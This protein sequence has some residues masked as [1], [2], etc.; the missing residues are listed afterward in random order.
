MSLPAE[1]S[2]VPPAWAKASPVALAF[3]PVHKRALG[4]AVGTVLGLALF[5]VTVFHVVL[6]P[7]NAPDIG[8]VGQYFYGFEVSWK[9]AFVGLFWGFVTGFVGGWFVAFTRNFITALKVFT[10]RTKA[11]LAQTKH[12][13]D[14]I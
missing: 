13:L 12:F 5:A 6:R 7:V 14:H 11:E 10:L 1:S 9:G 2:R 8:L 3:A 4:V